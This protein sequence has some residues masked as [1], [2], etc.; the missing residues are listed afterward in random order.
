MIEAS[1]ERVELFASGRSR[2]V[3]WDEWGEEWERERKG[4]EGDV[5]LFGGENR[6]RLDGCL[7]RG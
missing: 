4:A 2:R 7:L 3:G 5:M 1:E 6:G